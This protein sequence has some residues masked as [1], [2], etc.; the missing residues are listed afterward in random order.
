MRSVKIMVMN[1][2]EIISIFFVNI[3]IFF[4]IHRFHLT[5]PGKLQWAIDKLFEQDINIKMVA[6]KQTPTFS[7]RDSSGSIWRASSTQTSHHSKDLATFIFFLF[8]LP[9]VLSSIYKRSVGQLFAFWSQ[10]FPTLPS[11]WAVLYNPLVGVVF[12]IGANSLICCTV[13]LILGSVLS[14]SVNLMIKLHSFLGRWSLV[15][16]SPDIKQL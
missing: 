3:Y 15:V 11:W 9:T 12:L 4:K 8:L 14:D 10:Y 16:F 7:S 13:P 6:M 1:H 5:E 2:L